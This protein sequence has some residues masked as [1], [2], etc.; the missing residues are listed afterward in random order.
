MYELLFYEEYKISSLAAKEWAPK[1]KQWVRSSRNT[2]PRT[3]GRQ[4]S[5]SMYVYTVN[6]V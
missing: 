6:P 5:S 3:R 4:F 1:F 2:Q